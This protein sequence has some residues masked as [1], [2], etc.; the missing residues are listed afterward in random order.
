M[1]RGLWFVLSFIIV[2]LDQG[3]KCL[4]NRWLLPY[5]PQPIMPMFNL[6]LAYNSGAAFSFLSNAGEWHRWFFVSFS[7]IMSAVLI[8]WM[9]RLPRQALLQLTAI[10]LILGG[11]VG[12]LIDRAWQGYVIDFIDFYYGS[13]HWPVFN[14]ADSAICLGAFL[15]CIDCYKNGNNH[16][17]T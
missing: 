2:A 15:L 1:K 9:L 4:M 17:S 10:S 13:Y 7:F 11:A 8:I 14:I 12:N 3:S 5:E 6:N 16:C